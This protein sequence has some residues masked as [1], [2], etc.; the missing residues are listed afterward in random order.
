MTLLIRSAVCATVAA[1]QLAA[2][3][4][5]AETTTAVTPLQT[6]AFGSCSEQGKQQEIWQ[7]INEESPDL[8]IF[9][10]DNIY[11]DTEDMAKL[12]AKY[13]QFAANPGF[14]TLRQNTEV[15]AT[16]DDHDYGD[17]DAGAEYPM[18]DESRQI[19]LDFWDEPETS[20]RRSQEGGIYASYMYGP[21][22][23]RVQVILLD[24]RWNRGPLEK[25]TFGIMNVSRAAKNM[26]PY[27]PTEDASAVLLGEPQWAWLEAQLQ[28]DADVRIIGSSIQLLPEFSGWESWANF[29]HERERFFSLLKEHRATGAVII[30]GDVH[31]AELSHMKNA[32]GYPLWEITSSGLTEEWKAVSPNVHRIGDPY[33]KANYGLIEIDWGR[34]DPLL[35]WSINSETGERIMEQQRNLSELAD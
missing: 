27:E 12:R 25:A 34:D 21:P 28:E 1:V 26:G 9:L 5:P 32:I 10:G 6:I 23:K 29:P 15:I 35:T 16:W 18:K 4:N 13:G 31:W 8:F 2:I 19:M 33:S 20:P 3:A 7:A 14:A 30:S 11:G 22:G 17:N 24:L